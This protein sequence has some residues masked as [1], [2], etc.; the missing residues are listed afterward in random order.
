MPAA[1]TIEQL[2]AESGMTVR[3]I[4]AHQARGLLTPPEVRLRV[5]YYTPE[6][7]ERLRL[8]RELQDQGFNLAGIQRLLDE[9]QG[10]AERL[11]R[12]RRVLI[13]PPHAERPQMLTVSELADRFR[14]SADEASWV[15]ERAQRLGVLIRTG[16]DT[17]EAPSPTLLAVA[18]RVVA[19]GISLDGALAVF[20]AIEQHCDAVSGA[21]LRVF[22][23][24]VWNPFQ[25]AGMPEESWA[26]IEE[27]IEQLRP[28]ATEALVAIFGQRMAAQIDSAF[29]QLGQRSPG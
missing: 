4:R 19:R 6:H 21:F 14:L 5:G 22:L 7:V 24:E 20:E 13:E 28:L 26:E 18:E 1:L 3:N 11:N 15:M 10:P 8:I 29:G 2:A 27:S 17:F 16:S 23:D 9:D 25:A 12:F